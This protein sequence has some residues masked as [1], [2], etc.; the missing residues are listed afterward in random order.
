VLFVEAVHY[1]FNTGWNLVGSA[2][3]QGPDRLQITPPAYGVSGAAWNNQAFYISNFM[4]TIQL[5][6]TETSNPP[7][8]GFCFV[9]QRD[10]L[11]GLNGIGYA[12]GCL[13][14]CNIR[15]SVGICLDTYSGTS[16]NYL[17]SGVYKG[18]AVN[19]QSPYLILFPLTNG[20]LY[21][22]TIRYSVASGQFVW[23]VNGGGY[24]QDF[25]DPTGDITSAGCGDCP[26]DPRAWFGVTG[27]NGGCYENLIVSN[28]SWVAFC[29]AP[30]VGAKSY[31]KYVGDSYL[32][33]CMPAYYGTTSRRTAN[34]AD[35]T[36]S[37]G[38]P[39]C[40]VRV[41]LPLASFFFRRSCF[42]TQ[43]L[44]VF[45]H[46]SDGAPPYESCEA[47]HLARPSHL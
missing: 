43:Q 20:A 28:F 29:P 38:N 35:C 18:G 36:Y 42:H 32:E 41:L 21:T 16:P 3:L 22:Y 12:G 1:P 47:P 4:I 39:V 5:T 13:G 25:S 24:S 37:G 9:L 6:M 17:A 33:I 45:S 15:K 23:N 27:A 31:L 40:T 7:A 26:A 46:T 2:N 10:P 11:I 30:S 44:H 14:Y 19:Q 8:D 34:P